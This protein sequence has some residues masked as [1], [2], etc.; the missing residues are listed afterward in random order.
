MYQSGSNSATGERPFRQPSSSQCHRGLSIVDVLQPC[1]TYNKLNT[2]AWFRERVKKL[3]SP[4]ESR[5]EAIKQ[6][7]WTDEQILIGEFFVEDKPTLT[8][9]YPQLKDKTLLQKYALKNDI[10]ELFERHK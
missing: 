6:A 5:M 10:S 2:Y 7:I 4:L 8:D 9:K 1:V 3:E